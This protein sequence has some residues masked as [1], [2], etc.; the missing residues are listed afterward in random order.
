MIILIGSQSPDDQRPRSLINLPGKCE[1][2]SATKSHFEPPESSP[3]ANGETPVPC[4]SQKSEMKNPPRTCDSKETKAGKWVLIRF[5][6]GVAGSLGAI[7]CTD[8]MGHLFVLDMKLT[9][10][11]DNPSFCPSKTMFDYMSL[12]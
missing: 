11:H 8:W 2:V 10:G 7:P 12:C 9:T 6:G 5:G 1:L 4:S 3:A